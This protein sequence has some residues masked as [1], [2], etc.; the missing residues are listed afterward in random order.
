MPTQKRFGPN[1]PLLRRVRRHAAMAT[2]FRAAD[3]APTHQ[4]GP[5]NR[6]TTSP[7]VQ[8]VIVP[9]SAAATTA[10]LSVA[11][12]SATESS[13]GRRET[14]S[15]A[16]PPVQ[17]QLSDS[18]LPAPAAKTPASPAAPSASSPP[19]ESPSSTDEEDESAWRRLQ[20]I[21]RGHRQ[22][23]SAETNTAETTAP[24][25]PPP[26]DESP[27]LSAVQRQES[28]PPT[29]E[30]N[31]TSSTGR[32]TVS[33][34]RAE[35][36]KK[37][38]VS[39]TSP[40][41]EAPAKQPGTPTPPPRSGTADVQRETADE[42]AVGHG[43]SSGTEPMDTLIDDEAAVKDEAQAGSLST[44]SQD[45]SSTVAASSGPDIQRQA[46]TNRDEAIEVGAAETD[47]VAAGTVDAAAG[48]HNAGDETRVTERAGQAEATMATGAD[49][50]DAGDLE[51]TIEPAPQSLP[52]EAVWPVQRKEETVASPPTTDTAATAESSPPPEAQPEEEQV[53]SALQRVA[54]GQPTHSSVELVAPRRPRPPAPARPRGQTKATPPEA[55]QI[56]PDSI[57]ASESPGPVPQASETEPGP[58]TADA[59]P[60]EIGP[61]PADLWQLLGQAP[62]PSQPAADSPETVMRAI[63]TAETT[64]QASVETSAESVSPPASPPSVQRQAAPVTK[65]ETEPAPGRTEAEAGDKESEPSQVDVDELARRVYSD[66][67][68]RLS[69]EWERVRGRL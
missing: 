15:A 69:V 4:S 55:S 68:R 49:L 63:E 31:T 8:A 1:N 56:E 52:L 53:R 10:E 9:Q 26:A 67:K 41:A 17:R 35:S 44:T 16:E 5:G 32:E 12:A 65:A 40:T 54:S 3:P 64:G 39:P 46:Q 60:T 50:P 57:P 19:P 66:I 48:S 7:V 51:T 43:A 34:N 24:R 29:T 22:K 38:V 13:A 14:F 45:A 6:S 36:R 27:S 25:S 21:F 62:P 2:L 30:P 42:T 23:E 33:P 11:E 61:L 37:T 18:L 28:E 58:E 47:T 59:V 20:A